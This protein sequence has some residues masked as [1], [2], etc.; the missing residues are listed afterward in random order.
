MSE[1]KNLL[2]LTGVQK[3]NREEQK[4]IHGGGGRVPNCP[5]YTP[6]KCLSCGGG[7]L[8]NGCCIGSPQTL[9]C[10]TEDGGI[11]D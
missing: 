10:L 11:G 5:T 8:P 2:K 3:M 6:E 9:L 7:P 1:L 4:S